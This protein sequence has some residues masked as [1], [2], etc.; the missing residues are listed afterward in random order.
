MLKSLL[1]V[2]RFIL[3][4]RNFITVLLPLLQIFCKSPVSPSP[5]NKSMPYFPLRQYFKSSS[6]IYREVR[7]NIGGFLTKM[8]YFDCQCILLISK[9]HQLVI[10]SE[11]W[12]ENM[13]E[14]LIK[15]FKA[16]VEIKL[17][18]TRKTPLMSF[19]QEKRLLFQGGDKIFTKP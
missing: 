8:L 16:K 3:Q 4:I 11:L 7:P 5:P 15:I 17:T 10:W 9:L 18:S 1:F 19:W 2:C 6:A 12:I 13:I 14:Q